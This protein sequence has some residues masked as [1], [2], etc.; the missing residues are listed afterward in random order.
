MGN[1]II[2][3]GLLFAFIAIII[4]K[5][6]VSYFIFDTIGLNLSS[7]TVLNIAIICI[8]ILMI[9]GVIFDNTKEKYSNISSGYNSMRPNAVPESENKKPHRFFDID[10]DSIFPWN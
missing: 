8:A 9:F 6:A 4:K 1:E 7:K 2:F 10:F 3:F 5:E